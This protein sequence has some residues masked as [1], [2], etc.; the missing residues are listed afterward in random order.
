MT[1]VIENTCIPCGH[2]WKQRT[3]EPPGLCPKC[4]NP[5]WDRPPKYRRKKVEA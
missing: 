3:E 5:Y 4:K 2:K 1:T